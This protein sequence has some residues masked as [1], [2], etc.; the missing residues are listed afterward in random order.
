MP[1]SSTTKT[2]KTIC[3][4]ISSQNIQKNGMLLYKF[5]LQQPSSNPIWAQFSVFF[6]LSKQKAFGVQ[7]IKFI[8]D[9]QQTYSLVMSPS[10][11]KLLQIFHPTLNFPDETTVSWHVKKFYAKNQFGVF[12]NIFSQAHI[13]SF[14]LDIWSAKGGI[15]YISLRGH[16]ISKDW[17][18]EHATIGFHEIRA[19]HTR[20]AIYKQIVKI[21]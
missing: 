9:N 2:P 12:G 20:K 1:D 18:Q 8:I 4:A 11:Q 17:T 14:N 21:L 15:P 19:S 13:F 10:F 3:S 6:Q 5:R 7:L 16:Y